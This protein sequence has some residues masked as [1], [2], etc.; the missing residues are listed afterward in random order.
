MQYTIWQ[1]RDPHAHGFMSWKTRETVLDTTTV[2][3]ALY[4]AVYHGAIEADSG[5]DPGPILETLF[6]EFNLHHP[7]DFVGHSLSM[8]DVVSLGEDAYYYCDT[9]GWRGGAI[10][11]GRVDGTHEGMPHP[12]KG[13][14]LHE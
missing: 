10:E 6:A 14:A 1:P 11:H 9:V 7:A 12:S 13:G 3:L 2:D 4:Q 5:S 8:G